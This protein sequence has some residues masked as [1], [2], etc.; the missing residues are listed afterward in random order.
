MA[1]ASICKPGWSPE[2]SLYFPEDINVR[3]MGIFFSFFLLIYKKPHILLKKKI[4]SCSSSEERIGKNKNQQVKKLPSMCF[5][6]KYFCVQ[7]TDTGLS[8]SWYKLVLLH[9]PQVPFLSSQ[10]CYFKKC[11]CVH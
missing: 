10:Y 11:M 3:V 5:A 6:D 9:Q 1:F 4:G 8:L 7:T 2:Q